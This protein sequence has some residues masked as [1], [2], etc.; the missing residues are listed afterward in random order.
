M[1]VAPFKVQFM[2]HFTGLFQSESGGQEL[3]CKGHSLVNV[4]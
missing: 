3:G 4:V 1:R 2:K